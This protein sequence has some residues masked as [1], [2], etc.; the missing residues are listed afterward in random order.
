M[1]DLNRQLHRAG[2]QLHRSRPNFVPQ[3]H[4]ESVRDMELFHRSS[5]R[6]RP[7]DVLPV[8]DAEDGCVLP[9]FPGQDLQSKS[10]VFGSHGCRK[11]RVVDV[12]EGMGG[13]RW[14]ARASRVGEFDDDSLGEREAEGFEKDWVGGGGDIIRRWSRDATARCGEKSCTRTGCREQRREVSDDRP[15]LEIPS[16]QGR[17]TRA[18][19]PAQMAVGSLRGKTRRG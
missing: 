10:L 3:V 19:E 5:D 11:A 18:R 1:S 8:R 17:L 6:R 16:H 12:Q 7:N 9:F 13:W 4:R 15:L 2:P 14:V